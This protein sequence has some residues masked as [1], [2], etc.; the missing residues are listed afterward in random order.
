[1]VSVGTTASLDRQQRSASSPAT[2]KTPRPDTS[3]D[4]CTRPFSNSC[5]LFYV[6]DV[7]S[8][9]RFLVDTGSEVSVVPPSLSDHRRSPDPLT[10]MAVNNTHIR[11]YG[12]RSLILNLQVRR[13]LPWIFI[14]ADVQKPILGADFLRHFGLLVDMQHHKVIDTCTHLQV[15]GILS[16]DPTPSTSIRSLSLR[17]PPTPTSLCCQNSLPSHKPTQQEHRPTQH[18]P[19]H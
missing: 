16:T 8:H 14:I 1:M 4:R 17:T 10:L 15:Q 5:C 2:G 19:P 7:H 9:T 13:S 11:T 18:R 3:G 12:K 6:F